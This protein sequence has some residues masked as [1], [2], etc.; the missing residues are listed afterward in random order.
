MILKGIFFTLFIINCSSV[1]SQIERIYES[2]QF[3]NNG[4]SYF[5]GE[6]A[7]YEEG[8]A[9]RINIGVN[10]YYLEKVQKDDNFY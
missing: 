5:E 8:E 10:G 2:K 7:N 1:F 9:S 3:N 4:D 6:M